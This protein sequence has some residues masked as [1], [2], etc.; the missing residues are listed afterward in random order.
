M[1]SWFHPAA[2]EWN[3]FYHINLLLNIPLL[4]DSVIKTLV[5]I[6]GLSEFKVKLFSSFKALANKDKYAL[7]TQSNGILP[8]TIVRILQ[9]YFCYGK[10]NKLIFYRDENVF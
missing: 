5:S 1:S 7:L 9:N 3:R 10:I 6:L 2:F 4:I 8:C